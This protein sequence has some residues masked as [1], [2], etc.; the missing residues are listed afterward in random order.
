MTS[1][2]GDHIIITTMSGNRSELIGEDGNQNCKIAYLVHQMP[3]FAANC[4]AVRHICVFVCVYVCLRMCTIF[5][6]SFSKKKTQMAIISQQLIYK[7]TV[8]Y[9]I[10]HKV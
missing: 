8:K 4:L 2:L 7:C 1:Q 6:K 3:L 10:R 5:C 9:Q